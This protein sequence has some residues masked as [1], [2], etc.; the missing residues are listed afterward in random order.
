MGSKI[1]HQDFRFM[2]R[3]GKKNLDGKPR[4]IL[5]GFRDESTRENIL[6]R[7]HSIRAS[8]KFRNVFIDPDLTKAQIQ[9]H[10][11]MR[12]EALR[13]NESGNELWKVLG[14]KGAGRLVRVKK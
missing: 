1:D 9:D 12:R 11:N 2:F 3:I 7:S 10:D 13:R 6:R 4:A 5:V 8:E 14:R